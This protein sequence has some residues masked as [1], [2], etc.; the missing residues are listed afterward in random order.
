MTDNKL[1]QQVRDDVANIISRLE[2]APADAVMPKNDALTLAKT[3]IAALDAAPVQPAKGEVIGY[4]NPDEIYAKE[5]FVWGRHEHAHPKHTVALC[6]CDTSSK[7]ELTEAQAKEFLDSDPFPPVRSPADYGATL[8]LPYCEECCKFGGKHWEKC[9]KAEASSDA[10]WQMPELPQ[11]F[12]G[13]WGF[14][15]GQMRDYGL[16]C[17]RTTLAEV[18]A[19]SAAPAH[20][21]M[22]VAHLDWRRTYN[23]LLENT[24]AAAIRWGGAVIGMNEYV[25]HKDAL[26]RHMDKM[27]IAQPDAQQQDKALEVRTKKLK[28]F[29]A[30]ITELEAK[31]DT[32]HNAII[33]ECAKKLE[34]LHY[35]ETEYGKRFSLNEAAQLVRKTKGKTAPEAGGQS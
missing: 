4:L 12:P 22:P 8:T 28:E 2:A 25:R 6:R 11:P 3:L 14:T 29:A 17:R 24:L 1:K 16:K 30:R 9:S 5:A 27:P 18:A 32:Q 15:A 20:T 23:V 31:L 21:E 7:A 26:I 33:E 13:N 19:P 35:L 10:A 34:S